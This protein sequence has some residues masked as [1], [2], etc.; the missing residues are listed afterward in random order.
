[1]ILPGEPDAPTLAGGR[2]PLF[3]DFHSPM[4][5]HDIPHPIGDPDEDEGLPVDEEDDDEEDEDDDE[6]MQVRGGPT[7]C[8]AAQS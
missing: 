1:M 8:T 7:F 5:A 2:V 3:R 6:P 4:L